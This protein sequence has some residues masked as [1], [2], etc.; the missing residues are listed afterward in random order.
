MADGRT[1]HF[2]AIG[3]QRTGTTWLYETLRE[4]PALCLPREVKETLF[5]DRRYDRDLS[6]YWNYFDHRSPGQKCG[7]VAPTY[8]DTPEAPNRIRQVNPEIDII[9]SLR[10]PA[11]RTFSLYLHELR[12]QRVTG[13]F[14]EA[15]EEKP[16]IITSGHY[17]EHISRWRDAFG[18][19]NLHFIFMQ[20]IKDDSQKVLDT[21]CSILEVDPIPIPERSTEKVNAATVPRFPSLAQMATRVVS[22]LHDYRLHKVVEWGKQMGL[23]KIYTG[24]DMPSLDPRD[25]EWLLELY[26]DDIEYV[27]R[28]TGRDLDH[29]RQ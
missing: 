16:R 25:R 24:G 1:L 29:W 20:D 6:W 14:R 7:E 9:I 26:K 22:K 11:E 2:C 23:R 3:P 27:E 12:T 18:E 8:F 17:A 4:H 21:L 19:E 10:A 28:I 15:I 5:F 13:S